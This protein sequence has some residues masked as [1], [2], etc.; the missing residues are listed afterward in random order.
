MAIRIMIVDDH[1]VVRRGLVY[2]LE[3]MEDLKVVAEACDGME[4]I[5]LFKK[6]R[7]DVV[8]MDLDMPKMDGMECTKKLKEIDEEA[9]ILVLTSFTDQ[10]HV[11]PALEA[12]ASGYQLK[13]IEPEQ[14]AETIRAVFHGESRLHEKVTKHVLTRVSTSFVSEQD[15]LQKLTGRERDVLIEVTKGRSNKEIAKELFISEKTVKTHMSNILAKLELAD[16]TQAA[17]FAIKHKLR[18]R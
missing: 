1:H 3:T 2:F 6:E 11:I 18:K 14:L 15:R 16:R 10:D 5:E 9:I 13:D 8:I 12:G 17:V 7:P 4:A